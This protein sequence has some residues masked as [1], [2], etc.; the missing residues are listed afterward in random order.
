MIGT[1]TTAKGGGR[2]CW[3]SPSRS[4]WRR[5]TVRP[6][7]S[8]S[9]VTARYYFTASAASTQCAR[10]AMHCDCPIF[11][12]NIV[13][14]IVKRNFRPHSSVFREALI[15]P[16]REGKTSP[17][18]PLTCHA[19]RPSP[20][21]T[22]PWLCGMEHIDCHNEHYEGSAVR[23]P[24]PSPSPPCARSVCSSDLTYIPL[25]GR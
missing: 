21:R 17:S 7:V 4:P 10:T 2:A 6:S 23:C 3:R 14:L 22:S 19:K 12:P 13:D 15:L 1:Q 18:S 20:H 16:G 11:D 9:R 25:A 8:D 5:P 24:L